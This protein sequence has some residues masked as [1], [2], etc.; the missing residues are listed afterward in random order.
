MTFDKILYDIG[1]AMKIIIII[2]IH[3]T[4]IVDQLEEQQCIIVIV[5]SSVKKVSFY[6]LFKRGN[7]NHMENNLVHEL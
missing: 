6:M 2:I 4:F 7:K 1:L 3:K 5:I